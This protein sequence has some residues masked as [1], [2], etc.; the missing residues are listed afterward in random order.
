LDENKLSF[1]QEIRTPETQN[2]DA[3]IT[4]HSVRGATL[5][6]SAIPLGFQRKSVAGIPYPVFPT[7]YWQEIDTAAGYYSTRKVSILFFQ[8]HF[9][10]RDRFAVYLRL[11][12]Y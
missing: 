11:K 2:G 3:K 7:G 9:T 12:S 4:K 10:S 6:I 5:A 1:A 8:F